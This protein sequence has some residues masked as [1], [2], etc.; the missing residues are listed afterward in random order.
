LKIS[1]SPFSA[2]AVIAYAA[3]H[4]VFDRHI[5][6]S[7]GAENEILAGSIIDVS[8]RA[9]ATASTESANIAVVLDYVTVGQPYVRVARDGLATVLRQNALIAASDG[10]LATLIPIIESKGY[11]IHEEE[12][13]QTT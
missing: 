3:D 13:I 12:F 5:T 9:L 8:T 10:D 7:T 2:F 6:Y 4:L 1:Q 11:I